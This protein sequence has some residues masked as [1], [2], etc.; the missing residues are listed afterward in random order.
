M[1]KIKL[2]IIQI[3]LFACLIIS[4][5]FSKAL[6]PGSGDGDV[7]ANFLIL[8]DKSGSMQAMNYSGENISGLY[9]IEPIPGTGNYIYHTQYELGGYNDTTGELEPI[10]QTNSK[11]SV[12]SNYCATH[13]DTT[14]ILYHNNHIYFD[15]MPAGRDGPSTLCKVNTT[16]GTTTSVIGNLNSNSSF[17]LK[18]Y[19]DIIILIDKNDEKIYLHNSVTNN[20]V[21]CSPSNTLKEVISLA[22]E[23]HNKVLFAIDASGNLVFVSK[24]RKTYHNS[25]YKFP[26]NGM[27]CP[28]NWHSYMVDL[29]D[30]MQ[31]D[32]LT[33]MVA[34]PTVD[35]IIYLLRNNRIYKTTL[36]D[37]NSTTSQYTG[38]SG[39]KN[40][41]YYNPVDGSTVYFDSAREI[42]IDPVLKRIFVSDN[43]DTFKKVETYDLDLKYLNSSGWRKSSGVNRMSGAMEAIKSLVTDSSL[44]SSVNFGFGYWASYG[45][46]RY[47]SDPRYGD[48]LPNTKPCDDWIS[49]NPPPIP[50]VLGYYS[51]GYQNIWWC[52]FE[53]IDYSKVGYAEW[54]GNQAKPCDDKN[55]F[56]VRVN[57]NGASEINELMKTYI[58]PTGGTDAL[59]WAKMADDYYRHPT[60]SPIDT[61][62]P[63]QS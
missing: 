43:S 4:N 45:G 2:F 13:S 60:D 22:P 17:G 48:V 55:C 56:K 33:S 51:M 61:N 38:R 46:Y 8:L 10:V 24:Y 57:T 14:N 39:L 49:H 62:S 42:K 44:V 1:K 19:N 18:K 29:T 30:K 63:C 7:P 58:N 6:P 36:G 3:L 5:S 27:S 37:R 9:G 16:T 25:I 47:T 54:A 50:Y 32:N 41:L 34:H 12:D 59:I 31:L 52:G 15:G 40:P 35:K 20:T 21:T 23:K 53:P 28:N 26:L 11:Y